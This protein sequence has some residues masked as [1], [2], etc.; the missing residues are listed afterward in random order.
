MLQKIKSALWNN[1]DIII[2]LLIISLAFSEKWLGMWS[3]LIFYLGFIIYRLWKVFSHIKPFSS[4]G[5]V[6]DSVRLW[7][8][9]QLGHNLDSDYW[10]DK[11]RPNL[12]HKI[13][14]IN[15]NWTKEENDKWKKKVL[16][17]KNSVKKK[18]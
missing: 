11:K 14:G 7:E 12:W 5:M 13:K 16:K 1:I 10:K 6:A 17:I 9:E 8:S 4:A 18:K 3:F 15:P 2:L